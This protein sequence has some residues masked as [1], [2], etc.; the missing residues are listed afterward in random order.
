M[1]DT[2][3]IPCITARGVRIQLIHCLKEN[4]WDMRVK[5][6]DMNSEEAE[7]SGRGEREIMKVK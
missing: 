1:R 4:P 7:G 2:I 6:K 5:E 3:Y